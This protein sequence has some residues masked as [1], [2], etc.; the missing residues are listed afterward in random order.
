[1]SASMQDSLGVTIRRT[2]PSSRSRP[3]LRAV[4]TLGLPSTTSLRSS[5]F[6]GGAQLG[7]NYQMGSVVFGPEA[8]FAWTGRS[9]DV[10][11]SGTDTNGV[12]FTM[13]VDYSP[14]TIGDREFWLPYTIRSDAAERNPKR[15]KTFLAE[16]TNCRKFKAEVKIVP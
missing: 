9:V 6:I 4:P 16:Y 5:G 15:T 2:F 12:T 11:A 1:M 10:T 13:T 8:D 14:V 3:P 7:Y